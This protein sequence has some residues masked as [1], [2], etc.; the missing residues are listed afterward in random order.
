[1]DSPDW[2]SQV[3]NSDVSNDATAITD[4][5]RVLDEVDS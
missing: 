1:M 2:G 3:G 4:D 5:K